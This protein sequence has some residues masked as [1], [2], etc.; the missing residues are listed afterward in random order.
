MYDAL[1]NY[2]YIEPDN[3]EPEMFV[4]NRALQNGQ[5]QLKEGDRVHFDVHHSP[6]GN[7]AKNVRLLN[8]ET[9]KGS[10]RH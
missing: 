10:R 8:S 5:Q 1:R 4:D 3:G 7:K 2:G 6:D 9:L